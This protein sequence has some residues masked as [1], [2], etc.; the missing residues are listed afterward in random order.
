MKKQLKEELK[1]M[2]WSLLS[3][4]VLGFIIN[5]ILINII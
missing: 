5:D 3:G 1:I 4:I 2:I